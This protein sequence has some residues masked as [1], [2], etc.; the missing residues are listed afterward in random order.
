MQKFDPEDFKLRYPQFKGLA[1]DY[2]TSQYQLALI[3]GATV[4]GVFCNK[5][6]QYLISLLVLAHIL[7]VFAQSGGSGTAIGRVASVTEG[8]ISASFNTA[9]KA[10]DEFWAQSQFGL[11][12]LQLLRNRGGATYVAHPADLGGY[13]NYSGYY[14][15]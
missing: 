7:T 10:G 11:I 4:I 1:N 9:V 2:L 3:L 14:G 12:I 13:L 15:C 6:V 5:D 8:S